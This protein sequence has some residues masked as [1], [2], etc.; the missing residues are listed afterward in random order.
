[1]KHFQNI[2]IFFIFSLITLKCSSGYE[3]ADY[4][5]TEAT[6]GK[7]YYSPSQTIKSEPMRPYPKGG[8]P[9]SVNNQIPKTKNKTMQ[10]GA[11][12]VSDG[13]IIKKEDFNTES[14]SHVEENSFL[15][16]SKNPLSTFSI[17]VDTAS[18][19]NIRRFLNSGS[20]PPIDSVRI[21]EMINYF[22]YQYPP[23]DKEPF[24]INTEYSSCP[25]NP[26]HKL[27]LIALQG[28]KIDNQQMPPRNLVF[29]VDTSGSMEDA[30][31]LPLLRKAVNLLVNQLNKR[32]TL[33]IV[34][35]AG[36]AG[37]VLP[38]T[39]GDDKQKIL[40]SL[41]RLR[42]GGSTNGGAGIE[43]AYK[44][45]KEN[46]NKSGVNRV[47]LATDGD[48]NV[49]TSSEGDL[50]RLIEEQRKSGV[51]LSVLGFGMGN[52]KDSM[53]EKLANK[54]NGNYAY[55]D[56]IAEAKKVLVEQAGGT[57]VTIA[58]DVKIQIEFNPK[59]VSSY[60]LIGY[61]DRLLRNEDFNDDT[62]DAGEIGAGHTVTALYEIVPSNIEP[63]GGKVDPLKYQKKSELSEAA[64]TEELVTVKIRYKDPDKD[65]SKLLTQ[66][67][68]NKPIDFANAS[69][70]LKFASSVAGFGLLLRNS[71]HKG[72]LD[73]EK[74]IK[75][76]NQS[77]GEDSNGYRA[78]FVKLVNIAKKM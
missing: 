14:Y 35:Y 58:K 37:L 31:K 29:L 11:S 4:K 16:V 45:A 63:K 77:I 59:Y 23:P 34:A 46:F 74:L 36:S 26:D 10:E 51:F 19:S 68:Y 25:W 66:I 64:N 6:S 55:I 30:N 1:M 17:D 69:N 13:E 15:D 8:K 54:G 41:E 47:I 78:E 53:M 72:N 28:K 20:K 18:Y 60:R 7:N 9:D 65:T 71:K 24:S 67:I 32:D 75:M 43:L 22:Y 49:G 48:F 56:T 5:R 50:V 70:N 33:S 42:A 73:Y 52:Y 62:K 12:G 2:I 61:E 21:E 38:P 27:A 39:K 76:A 44:T 57:L 3:Q 40:E